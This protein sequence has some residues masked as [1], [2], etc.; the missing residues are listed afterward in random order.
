MKQAYIAENSKAK[1]D[2]LFMA[3]LEQMCNTAVVNNSSWLIDSGCTNHMTTD[4]S[5][6]KDL[7]KSY[8]SKVRTG[9]EEY[10]KVEGKGVIEVETM[11][12]TKTLKNM[13]YVPKINQN[14]VSVGQLLESGY[15]LSFNDGMCNIRDKM[16]ILLLSAKM[17]NRSFNIDW[18]EACLSVNTCVIKEV[19]IEPILFYGIKDWGISIML[20]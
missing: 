3:T 8:M 5:L 7:D 17:M 11:S 6:F 10:V 9:N 16:G 13:L 2:H 20:P 12:G 4:L 15:S 18:K 1:E 19:L 14:L